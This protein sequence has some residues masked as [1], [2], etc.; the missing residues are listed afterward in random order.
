M[1]TRFIKIVK[2]QSAKTFF[3]ERQGKKVKIAAWLEDTK[4]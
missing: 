3:A 1:Y 4:H 2:C